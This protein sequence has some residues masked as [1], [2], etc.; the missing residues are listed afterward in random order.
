LGY[1]RII[2]HFPHSK[3]LQLRCYDWEYLFFQIRP[4]LAHVP[5]CK[6]QPAYVGRM[7]NK[8]LTCLWGISALVGG[9]CETSSFYQQTKTLLTTKW[10]VCEQ[11]TPNFGQLI[12]TA[13]L[14][15]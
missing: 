9:G 1:D 15:F 2:Q 3:A 12:G 6:E 8:E 11:V 7:N 14:T 5:V 10:I 4:G 13:H